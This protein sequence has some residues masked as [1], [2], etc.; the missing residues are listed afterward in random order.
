MKFEDIDVEGVSKET[1]QEI[2]RDLHNA[3]VAMRTTA[4]ELCCDG[5][6]LAAAAH[7]AVIIGMFLAK[8]IGIP[9]DAFVESV[10]ELWEKTHVNPAHG[11]PSHVAVIVDNKK[12]GAPS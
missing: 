9:K 1:K 10:T 5:M 3:I 11:V 6:P 7:G 2:A 8:Q 12:M 4:E